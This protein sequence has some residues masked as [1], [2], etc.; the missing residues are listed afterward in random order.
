MMRSPEVCG[1]YDDNKGGGRGAESY[2]RKK[3]WPSVNISKLSGCTM[4]LLELV[5]WCDKI[6]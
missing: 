2:Y 3:A 4:Q 5:V 1:G 6:T